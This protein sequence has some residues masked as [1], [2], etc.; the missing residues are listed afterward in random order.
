M[1]TVT[2]SS[3][4]SKCIRGSCAMKRPTTFAAAFITL[5]ALGGEARAHALAQRYDLPLPLGYFLV[6][7]GAAVVMTF[8]I[9]ALFWRHSDESI[10]ARNDTILRGTVPDLVV[11]GLQLLAVL[12]L[13][14]LVTAGLFGNPATFKNITPVAVW[15]IWWVGFGFLT[16][17]VGNIWPLINP[18]SST[19][20]FFERL[21]RPWTKGLS[22]HAHY[23]RW[24]GVWPSCALFLLFAWLE[25]VAPGRDVPRNIAIA[26]LIYS[27]FTWIGFTIFGRDT[28]L[29]CG[30]VFSIAFGLFG[31]FAPLDFTHDDRWRVSL[32]PFAIGLLPRAPLEPSMTAFSL[33]MLGTVTVDGI[34]ETPLWAVA[35]ERIFAIHGSV[36]ANSWVYMAMQTALLIAGP[37]MLAGLYLVVI[38]LMARISGLEAAKLSGLFVL[39]LIPI[40]IAYHL[41]HYFSLF[42]VAG[43]FIIPLASDPFGYGWDLF[44]TK[45]YRIDIGIVDAKTIWYLSVIAIVTGH[46]IA[47]WIGHVTASSVFRDSRAVGRSQYPMLVLMVCYTML[48]LWILAQPI[49]EPNPK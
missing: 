34:M 18:W 21:T 13:I 2:R 31:R 49:V 33:L 1:V 5:A 30:E 38:A 28:W 20:G 15:V 16:A 41:S 29:K 26:I 4:I 14:L 36:D 25:L 10:E 32:R 37:L 46:V 44:D 11:T 8:V 43:Q 24:L 12:A 39:S 3:S 27:V 40:A 47:V 19:F 22:F 17:F 6:A 7:S 48:S 42:L 45:L 9:L 23:P 35:V